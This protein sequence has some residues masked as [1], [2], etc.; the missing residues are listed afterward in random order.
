MRSHLL[1]S[2]F[3]AA[4]VFAP[5]AA[6]QGITA[7][8]PVNGAPSNL[9]RPFPGGIGRYQQWYSGPNLTLAGF[10][11]P[12]RIERAEFFAGSSLSSNATVIDMEVSICHG[13]ASGLTGLF[14]NNY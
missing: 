12:V 4:A 6:A 3:L 11:G 1:P 14:S 9:D 8:V 2:S 5:A 10:T 13:A 7:T